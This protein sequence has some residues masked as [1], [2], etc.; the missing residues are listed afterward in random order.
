MH[1]NLPLRALRLA[2]LLVAVAALSACAGKKTDYKVLRYSSYQHPYPEP[3]KLYVFADRDRSG[4]DYLK[5]VEAFQLETFR[6]RITQGLRSRR[7]RI[8]TYTAA[9]NPTT[10]KLRN[11]Y[12]VVAD[13]NEADILLTLRVDAFDE[14]TV[15][16]T[17]DRII[18]WSAY[19]IPYSYFANY[20]RVP[21]M[22]VALDA[23]L[24]ERGQPT[25]FFAFQAQGVAVNRSI[26]RE[27]FDIAMDRC[28]LRFYERLLRQ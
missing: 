12:T 17:S 4:A 6:E 10:I 8:D 7:L 1:R 11:P 22:L 24:R 26:R 18:F 3:L 9:G 14:S 21:R 25:T 15:D 5:K 20:Q 13:S 27:G 16:V 2:A 19:G 28:E 23:Q